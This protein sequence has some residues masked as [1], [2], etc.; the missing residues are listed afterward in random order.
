MTNELLPGHK[1][2][3]SLASDP[4]ANVAGIDI[5]Q[6]FALGTSSLLSESCTTNKPPDSRSGISIHQN[7]PLTGSPE[8]IS[9]NNIIG[10]VTNVAKVSGV[11]LVDLGLNKY[12]S[13]GLFNVENFLG[14]LDEDDYKFDPQIAED[15]VHSPSTHLLNRMKNENTA[16]EEESAKDLWDPSS[17]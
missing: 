10:E 8:V 13:M 17:G 2:V 1:I 9:G 15:Q 6:P 16:F 3:G 14:F 5:I 11:G 12:S 7:A 4:W